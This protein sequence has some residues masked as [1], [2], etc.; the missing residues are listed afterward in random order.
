MKTL[1]KARMPKEDL[2]L[3]ELPL[4]APP[5]GVAPL[6][7]KP[8]W[9]KTPLKAEMPLRVLTVGIGDRDPPEAIADWVREHKSVTKTDG[10]KAIH[11][12]A[13][14]AQPQGRSGGPMLDTQGRVIGICTGKMNGKGYYLAIDEIFY[15]LEKG[16]YRFLLK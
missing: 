3:I 9:P 2:A 14:L 13:D 6:C 5:P 12:E 1:V 7:P 16:G 11:W 4:K 8:D 10:T 15:L